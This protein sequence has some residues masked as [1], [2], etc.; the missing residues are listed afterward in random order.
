MTILISARYPAIKK[1]G[2]K[3]HLYRKL[4]PKRIF[5]KKFNYYNNN[6]TLPSLAKFNIN[7]NNLITFWVKTYVNFNHNDVKIINL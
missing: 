2:H 5:F 4:S 7:I 1:D 6:I 3:C